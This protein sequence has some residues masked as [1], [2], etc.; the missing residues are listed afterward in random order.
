[1]ASNKADQETSYELLKILF[2]PE[3][4]WAPLLKIDEIRRL[5]EPSRQINSKRSQRSSEQSLL[6]NFPSKSAQA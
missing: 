2:S 4:E 6:N 3:N 1:M 5:L